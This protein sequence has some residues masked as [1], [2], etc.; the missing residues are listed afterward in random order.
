[1]GGP[2]KELEGICRGGRETGAAVRQVGC[3]SQGS[4]PCNVGTI[5]L[6]RC[7][8]LGYWLQEGRPRTARPSRFFRMWIAKQNSRRLYVW[9]RQGGNKRVLHWLLIPAFWWLKL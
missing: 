7:P 1:M 8:L 9:G 3:P 6:R 5:F 2:G 4:K